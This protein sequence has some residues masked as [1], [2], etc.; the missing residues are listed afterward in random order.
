MVEAVLFDMDGVITETASVHAAAWKR[1]FDEF[2]EARARRLGEPYRPFDA[3]GEYRACVDG[4]PRL[5]GVTHFLASR[6]IT[7]ERG[8]DTDP[9]DADTVHGL[10]NR[11]NGYFQ[12]WLR[13][14][15]VTP[16]A[17]AVA[18]T[19]TLRRAGVRIAV[20]SASRNATEVLRSA[21][22]LDRFDAI[23]TGTDAEAL[24]IPGKPDPAML[25]EAATR[26][27]VAPAEASVVEDA[28]AGIEAGVRG[29]FAQVIGIDRTSNSE[30]L[31]KAGADL[32]V[33][34]LSELDWMPERG[35]VVRTRDM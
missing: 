19:A 12:D 4:R 10:G 33:R 6:G 17:G 22:V 3:D 13:R 31:R 15:P 9:P 26:L 24:G 27:G 1:A 30:A 20:F 16:Y 8:T 11:K 29:G 32:V 35:L 34:H 14:H 7:L 21:G 5:D 25:L 18:L 2:L 28:T 23:V